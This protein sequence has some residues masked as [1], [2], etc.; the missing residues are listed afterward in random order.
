MVLNP[1]NGKVLRDT[2]IEDAPEPVPETVSSAKV[3]PVLTQVLDP[4]QPT[5][6]AVEAVPHNAAAETA[7]ATSPAPTS[8]PSPASIDTAIDVVRDPAVERITE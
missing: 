3:S 8:T 1:R 4:V 5:R 2:I 7:A 6:P